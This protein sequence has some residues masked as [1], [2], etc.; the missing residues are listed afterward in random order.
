M[1]TMAAAVWSNPADRPCRRTLCTMVS[2]RMIPSIRVGGRRF[3]EVSRV[4]AALRR[5]ETPAA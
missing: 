1:E 3:F 2:K 5:Y 4:L